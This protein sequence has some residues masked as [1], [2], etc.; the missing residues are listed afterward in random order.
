[1]CRTIPSHQPLFDVDCSKTVLSVVLRR[2]LAEVTGDTLAALIKNHVT[3]N[4]APNVKAQCE[5]C[6]NRWL[7]QL[8]QHCDYQC[9]LEFAYHSLV[10]LY[11]ES[12]VGSRIIYDAWLNIILDMRVEDLCR[13]PPFSLEELI[14]MTAETT[15]IQP[16]LVVESPRTVRR[17]YTSHVAALAAA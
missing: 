15:A 10:R 12:R 6:G 7:I 1:M 3:I 9:Q 14:A 11:A 5:P 4:I 13:R 16:G 8:D 17:A 2:I